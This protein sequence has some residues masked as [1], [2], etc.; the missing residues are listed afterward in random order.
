MPSRVVLL[1]LGA[2]VVTA[3]APAALPQDADV[4]TAPVLPTVASAT[5]EAGPVKPGG[6]VIEI[7]PPDQIQATLEA[8][9]LRV[10]GDGATTFE[11]QLPNGRQR[12]LAE[13]GGAS[14]ALAWDAR[15][16]AWRYACA[17]C[18]PPLEPGVRVFDAKTG[19]DRLVL[20]DAY[21]ALGQAVI[22]DGQ[23]LFVRRTF[24][25]GAY[26]GDLYAVELEDPQAVAVLVAEGVFVIPGSSQPLFAGGDG[27]IGWATLGASF[28]DVR[29]VLLD[30]RQGAQVTGP[31][32]ALENPSAVEVTAGWLAWR[33]PDGWRVFS[34]DTGQ[35]LAFAFTTVELETAPI[36]AIGP[37]SFGDGRLLWSAQVAGETRWF[38]GELPAR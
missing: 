21:P 14:Q 15:F 3:C 17:V 27:Q 37:A 7:T 5:S 26:T 23:L 24:A 16:L 18:V 1:A 36:G 35:V 6:A 38:A 20:A 8:P 29:W 31:A 4:P 28:A 11:V 2:W 32:L 19:T 9:V 12:L 33:E 10:G 22:A 30:R 13:E 34:A 25:T